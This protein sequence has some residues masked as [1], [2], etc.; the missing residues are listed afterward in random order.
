MRTWTEAPADVRR[1]GGTASTGACAQ[2]WPAWWAA[3]DTRDSLVFIIR[4]K[5][6]PRS[7]F[8]VWDE[9]PSLPECSTLE[10][11]KQHQALNHKL[12][13]LE[14][15]HLRNLTKCLVP[16]NFKRYQMSENPITLSSKILNLGNRFLNIDIKF[17]MLQKNIYL[18][19]VQMRYSWTLCPLRL[20]LDVK[21]LCIK[22]QTL[23]RRLGEHSVYS[24]ACHSYLYGKYWKAYQ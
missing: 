12:F 14:Q 3:G 10:Q 9:N 16:C 17:L 2:Q 6:Y 7:V 13:T 15:K 22:R 24:L 11:L 1:T 5:N 19:S 23:W 8:E 18:V 20:R 4:Q 21:L